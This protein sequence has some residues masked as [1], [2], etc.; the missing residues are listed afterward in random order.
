MM[1]NLISKY[2]VQF[3]FSDFLRSRKKF[4]DTNFKKNALVNQ[5]SIKKKSNRAFF[6]GMSVKSH[7]QQML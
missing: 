4:H 5:L 7:R 6:M 3:S 1:Y 2:G